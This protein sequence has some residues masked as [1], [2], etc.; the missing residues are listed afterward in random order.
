MNDGAVTAQ[1]GAL[2]AGFTA[3]V[4]FDV[5]DD[6]SDLKAVMGQDDAASYLTEANSIT[7]D[8]DGLGDRVVGANDGAI[9]ASFTADV[10]FDV[11][12]SAQA[13]AAELSAHGAGSLD[14]AADVVASGS[15]VDA[16]DAAVFMQISEYNTA[17]SNYD[18]R[19]VCSGYQCWFRCD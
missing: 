19:D 1:D 15:I 9:L 3:D 13:I 11:V 6:V 2:L 7:V 16:E 14:E 12:D 18:I 4:H 5:V 10:D 17:G 8:N